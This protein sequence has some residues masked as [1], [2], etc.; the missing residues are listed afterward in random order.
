VPDYAIDNSWGV[1]ARKSVAPDIIARLNGEVVRVHALTDVRERYASL[2][3]EA[4]SSTPAVFAQVIR[5]D[6]AK[7]S[8]IIKATGAKVD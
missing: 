7:Y 4:V 1:F 8:N 3:L 5:D 6:A 2:G